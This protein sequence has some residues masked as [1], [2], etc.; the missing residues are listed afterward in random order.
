MVIGKFLFDI[1]MGIPLSL[2]TGLLGKIREEVEREGLATE[3]SIKARLQTLQLSLEDGKLT[4]A[5]YDKLEA[6]L[7]ERL[8]ALRKSERM[9]A[10]AGV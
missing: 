5:E 10:D 9:E 6:Y 7:I 1:T 8:M 3:E 2:S 4:E